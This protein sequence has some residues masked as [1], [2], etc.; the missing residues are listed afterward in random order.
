MSKTRHDIVGD[1]IPT[2]SK[3]N[4][5]LLDCA[6]LAIVCWLLPIETTWSQSPSGY[7]LLGRGIN[8]GNMLEAPSEGEWG[9][10]FDDR[11][12]KMIKTVG[13]DSVRVPVRWS[14][15]TLDEAPYQIQPQYLARVR[16]VVDLNL[17]AGLKV[18]LNVHHFE[19][20]YDAPNTQRDRFLA[21]W[22][23]LSNAFQGAEEGLIFEILNEPH[24]NLAADQWNPLM[25]DA[26]AEIR[27]LHPQRWVIVG[28]DQWNSIGGLPGLELP[29][30]DRR[31][32]VTVHYYLPFDFT[33]QGASWVSPPRPTG[34]K[35]SATEAERA[36]VSH[37]M[38]TVADWASQQRRPIYVGEFGAYER[39]EMQSCA[40][41]TSYVRESCETRKFGWAYWELASGFGVLNKE[42]N[43]WKEPLI[44]ALLPDQES[45]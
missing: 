6:G 12:P 28:P 26:L 45:N 17:Q 23:Q 20:L 34:V 10:R 27:K 41:W 33:H 5:R 7:E 42:T 22:K 32:I 19:E 15:A 16:H 44:Q 35:W 8:Y 14:S 9:L 21:I 3:W 1:L 2:R 39:A 11:Y 38:Q 24:G 13:F 30:D 29:E 4:R 43:Q 31:L 40:A 25:V 36:A 37:D 18:V